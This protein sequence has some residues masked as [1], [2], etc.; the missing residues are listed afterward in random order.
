MDVHAPVRQAAAILDPYP[1]Q[2]SATRTAAITALTAALAAAADDIR[3]HPAITL[4]AQ[5]ARHMASTIADPDL[6]AGAPVL[7]SWLGR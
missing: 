3:G 4:E 1:G 7:L 6:T 5:H 2:Q